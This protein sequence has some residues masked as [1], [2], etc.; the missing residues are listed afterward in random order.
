[1]SLLSIPATSKVDA[2][3]EDEDEDEDE[4][5]SDVDLGARVETRAASIIG[6]E[7]KN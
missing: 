6:L 3:F 5:E 2:R 1:L 7:T 4:D